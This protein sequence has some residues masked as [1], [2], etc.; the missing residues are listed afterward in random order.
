MNSGI[1][2]ASILLETKAI[3]LNF[4][5]KFKWASGIESPI[6]C[7]N[8]V[9]ISYVENRNKIVDYF[10][11]LINNNFDKVDLIAGVATSGISWAAMISQKMNLPMIY[12]RPEPKDH[13]RNS[14]IEGRFFENQNVVVIEDLISTGGSVLKVC[15]LL[16][17]KNLNVQGVC[18]IFSYN[19]IKAKNNFEQHSKKLL[20]LSNKEYLINLIK[21]NELYSMKEIDLLNDFFNKLDN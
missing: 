18:S 2:V 12:V 21:E 10:I 20:T 4:D 15:D 6:Y 3:D 7:D 5:K 8:R 9:L 14:Q 1:E 17:D 16:D 11:E 19:L 13:G